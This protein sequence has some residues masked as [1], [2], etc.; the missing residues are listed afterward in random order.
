MLNF[1]IDFLQVL[2]LFRRATS[3]LENVKTIQF[4]NENCTEKSYQN[5]KINYFFLIESIFVACGIQDCT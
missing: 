3:L 4:N 1:P 2:L 5:S